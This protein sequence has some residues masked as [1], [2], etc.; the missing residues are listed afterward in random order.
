VAPPYPPHF[1]NNARCEY[2]AGAPGH[3]IE[4]CKAFKYKVQELLDRKLISFKEEGPNVKTNPL[5]GH[6]SSSVNAVEE[7]EEMDL[8]KEVSKIKTPLSVVRERLIGFELFERLHSGCKDCLRNPASCQGMKESLQKLIDQGLVQIGYSRK[9]A[10]IAVVESLDPTPFEIPYQ[11]VKVE[12]P[13]KKIDP[14][15]FHIPAPFSFK[16]TKEVPWNYLP[17]VSVGEKSISTVEPI[18]DNIAGIGGMTRSGR[19]FSLDPPNKST[20]NELV[21]STKRKA[22]E[23]FEMEVGQSK[24]MVPQEGAEEFL[25]IIRKSDYKIIDQLGQTPSK[26]S[27]LSLLLSSEA[28]REALLKILNEAHVTKDITVDQFDGV[29]ANITTSRYLGFNESELPSEGQDHN[30]AL[31]ISVKCSDN[32]LSKVLV[33][34]GSSLN[35]MPKATLAKLASEGASLRPSSLIVKAFDGSRRAVMGEVDLPILIGPQIFNITFQIMDINPAYSCLLG[36]PWIH[37][38]GAVTSTLHQKLK[39]ITGDKMIVVSGQEDM[40]VSHLSS[41]RYIEADEEAIE[42][43][44]QALEIASVTT[45]KIKR[46]KGGLAM[47]SWKAMK[48]ALEEGVPLGWGKVPEVCEKKDRFGLG[49]R[50]TTKGMLGAAQ[51]KMGTLQEIFRSAGFNY[52]GDVAM[53]EDEEDKDVLNLVHQC[54]PDEVLRNWKA[55]EIPE[56][57]FK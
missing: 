51:K 35:V 46:K 39:F 23:E 4:S 16:S 38:A 7:V 34:T 49:Y 21:G 11:R 14:M 29:V 45:L 41:F 47:T 26:I 9:Y 27:I 55:W 12:I 54:A 50:P 43:P 8:L 57:V 2:H 15:I 3:N 18:V 37:A 10:S 22:A 42:V 33:D 36:R 17:N 53:M 19:I 30:K 48:E 1:D 56:V 40:M 25:R 24:K 13:V 5:P 44:F 52:E 6:A 32:I 20:A 31:H 28:H